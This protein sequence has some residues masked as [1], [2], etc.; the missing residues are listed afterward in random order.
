MIEILNVIIASDDLELN[1]LVK[2]AVDYLIEHQQFLQ[3]DPVGILQIV[4]SHKSLNNVQEFCLKMVC[5]KPEILFDSAEFV[6]L[7]AP[8]L[9]VILKT[10]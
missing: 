2:L 7:P 1:Q 10:R 3:D 4:Y 6:N 9:E 8:L 5:S